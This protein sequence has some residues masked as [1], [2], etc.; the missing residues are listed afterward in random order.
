MNLIPDISAHRAKR[1]LNAV[2][3]VPVINNA[4]FY[5]MLPRRVQ[6][7]ILT[8]FCKVPSRIFDD[9]QE[10]MSV[11]G[12]RYCRFMHKFVAVA[13]FRCSLQFP[14]ILPFACR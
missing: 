6:N 13:S 3:Y 5:K 11:G 9:V 10:F 4:I 2:R 1:D 12:S 8:D 7:A 14:S